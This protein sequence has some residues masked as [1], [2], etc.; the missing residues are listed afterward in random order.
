MRSLGVYLVLTL[1]TEDQSLTASPRSASSSRFI[2]TATI[3]QRFFV[4]FLVVKLAGFWW[5]EQKWLWYTV[6]YMWCSPCL[7]YVDSA[8]NLLGLSLCT[9]GLGCLCR[10]SRATMVLV[11]CMAPLWTWPHSLSSSR[12]AWRERERERERAV[13]RK[14]RRGSE[15][16]VHNKKEFFCKQNVRMRSSSR[17][18]ACMHA[19]LEGALDPPV[20]HAPERSQAKVPVTVTVPL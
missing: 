8:C 3:N 6:L 14:N 9:F 2:N 17:M 15:G 5:R 20:Q 13:I 16:Y 19:R 4:L 10:R 12:T 11:G 7:S 18:C 1:Q